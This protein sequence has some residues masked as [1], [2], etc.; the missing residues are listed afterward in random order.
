MVEP[1]LACVIQPNCKPVINPDD[2]TKQ[3]IQKEI[4]DNI[5]RDLQ[6]IDIAACGRGAVRVG[7]KDRN[8]KLIA[9]PEFFIQ[10]SVPPWGPFGRTTEDWLKLSINIPGPE[11]EMFAEKAVEHDI[12]VS[13]NTYELI[14]D[15]YQCEYRGNI[16]VKNRGNMDMYFVGEEVAALAS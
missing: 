2:R 9:F 4:L 7:I 14:K 15:Q 13:G 3:G 11:I 12:Y 6:L 10:G 16:P 5:T 8:V 1:Y